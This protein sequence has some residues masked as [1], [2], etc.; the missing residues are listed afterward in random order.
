MS[1]APSLPGSDPEEDIDECCDE[2]AGLRRLKRPKEIHDCPT[3]GT[4][5]EITQVPG[6]NYAR[7]AVQPT[8]K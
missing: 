4:T 7:K 8:T 1:K 5:L 6:G 3:C 2:F